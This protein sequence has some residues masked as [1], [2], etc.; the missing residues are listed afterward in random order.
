MQLGFYFDQTRCTGC[1]ACRVACKD[2]YDIPAGPATRIRIHYTEQ[3]TWP[4]V[5]AE[6]MTVACFQCLSPVCV[7]AC[8]SDA[9]SKRDEDGIVLVD[10]ESCVGFDQCEGACL[11][12]CPYDVP[13]FGP[14]GD[15]KMWKCDL[16]L[17]RLADEKQAICVESCPT[18]ALDVGPLDE[19]KEKYGDG[20]PREARAGKLK[21]G[22][23][24]FFSTRTNPAIV[25]KPKSSS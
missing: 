24:F 9:I 16:C 21:Q 3:G 19:L 18:R 20:K 22:Q 1:A 7:D 2:W 6:Y 15:D 8:P 4:D 5:S 25:M 11:K 12:A 14:N 23:P 17:E 13:Q 10:Y